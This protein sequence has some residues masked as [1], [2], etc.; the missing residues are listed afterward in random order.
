MQYKKV[1]SLFTRKAS[2]SPETLTAHERALA[3]HARFLLAEREMASF[4]KISFKGGTIDNKLVKQKLASLQAVEAASLEVAQ[5]ASHRWTIASLNLAAGA[6]EV[7]ADFFL[8]APVP[9]GLTPDQKQQYQ[10]LL[11]DKVKP[12]REKAGQFRRAALDKAYELGV[13][14]PEVHTC[15][16]A[17]NSGVTLPVIAAGWTGQYLGDSFSPAEKALC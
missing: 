9:K 15:F 11:E 16:S 8:S 13:F 6:N 2:S 10:Q 12:Y 5:Y 4:K 1:G 17:L 3:A 14:S 7:L